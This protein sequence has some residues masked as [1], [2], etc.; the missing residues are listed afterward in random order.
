[1]TKKLAYFIYK[2]L[3]FID[4]AFNKITK[5]SFLIWFVEFIQKDSYKSIKISDKKIKF[6]FT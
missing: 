2:I 3:F 4:F 6:F 5:R 1:M